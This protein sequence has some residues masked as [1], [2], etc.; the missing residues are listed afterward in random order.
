MINADLNLGVPK[1]DEDIINN[2][3]MNN[4]ISDEIA[5]KL[6]TMKV[7]RNILVHRYGEIDDALAFKILT[8]NLNDFKIFIDVVNKLLKQVK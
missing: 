2:L 7:F 8:K 5:H 6:K 4:I 1:K 3:K